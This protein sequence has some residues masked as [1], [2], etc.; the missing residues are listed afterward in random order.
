MASNTG[1]TIR[2]VAL[3]GHSGSGKTMLAEAMLFKGGELSRL[4][5]VSD[6]T[7][8][9]D[10]DLDEKEGRKSFYSALLHTT[11]KSRDIN[12]L[13]TPGSAD[14]IGQVYGALSV[15]ELALIT[16]NAA[17]G[18][19]VG[20]RKAWELVKQQGCACMFVITRMD[21]ENARFDEVVSALQE[22]FGPA[23]TPLMLPVGSGGNFRGVVNLLHPGEVPDTMQES[24]ETQRGVLME[25]LISGDDAL[26]ERYLEGETIS[27]AELERVFTPVLVER[28]VIP[29]LCCAAE[30]MDPH[31]HTRESRP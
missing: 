10:F 21:A 13:D 22:T 26:L 8:A 25:S 1:E 11:W 19:E 23:C 7:T 30:Q 18:I 24:V 17:A 5:K 15:V 29:I 14:F 28:T 9:S 27:S 6:G 3:G 16:V 2:N 4:G 20:T 12:I 31:Q